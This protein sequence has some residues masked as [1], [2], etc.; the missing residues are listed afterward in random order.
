MGDRTPDLSHDY[1]KYRSSALYIMCF[2]LW[3]MI[4][5][6]IK[7]NTYPILTYYNVL[8]CIISNG[9]TVDLYIY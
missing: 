8:D 6:N 7:I 5:V 9:Y 4:I 3:C 1:S 2:S